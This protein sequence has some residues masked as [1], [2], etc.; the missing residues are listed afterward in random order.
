MKNK[1]TAKLLTT[2]SLFIIGN[3]SLDASDSI[4]FFKEETVNIEPKIIRLN[5]IEEML[6]S[7]NKELLSLMSNIKEAEM[8]LKSSLTN[9]YPTIDLNANGMTQYLYGE[10][11]SSSGNTTS[12]QWKSSPSLIIN[13]NLIDPERKA[14]IAASKNSLEIAKNNYLIK[15]R[16]LITEARKRFFILQK[17]SEE[18][19]NG[20]SAVQTSKLSLKDAKS[21]FNSGLGTKLDILEAESQLSRDSQFLN[22]RINNQSIAE[23]NLDH[24][25]YLAPNEKSRIISKPSIIGFWNNSFKVSLLS[26]QE[27]NKE[28]ANIKESRKL[29]INQSNIAKAKSKPLVS[30]TNT[31]S[32]SFTKGELLSSDLDPKQYG[33]S[34][35]NQIAL[36]LSWRIFDGGKSYYISKGNKELAKANEIEYE[37]TMSEISN[38]IKSLFLNLNSNIINIISTQREIETTKEQLRISKLRFNAGISTQREVI[39]SQKELTNAKT[40][41]IEAI[42]DYNINL[43]KLSRITGLKVD[44]QCKRDYYSKMKELKS[45]RN[46][47]CNTYS[48]T[49]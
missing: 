9:W 16:D 39:N 37:K 45:L 17:A 40:K 13:W 35:N 34:Y 43:D 47:F 18:V 14:L 20:E 29:N 27:Y 19:K 31:F 8:K 46:S 21:K 4:L 26:A 6:V 3:Y 33:S 15:K 36:K 48:K 38:E 12:S 23:N 42:Y 7:N 1:F 49:N 10:Q 2:L 28:I 22:T 25:L 44:Y 11:Y 5:N 41:N 32:S 24:I 30:L